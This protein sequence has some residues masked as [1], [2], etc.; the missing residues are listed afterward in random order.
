[1]TTF[2]QYAVFGLGASAIY[3]LLALGLIVI[4]SGSGV[5][6]FA[7]AAMATLGA[8]L[9]FEMRYIHGWGFWPAFLFGV[10]VITLIGVLIYHLVMRPLRDASALAK[11]IASLGILILIQGVIAL[12]WHENPRNVNAIFPTT[13]HQIGKVLIPGDRIYLVAIAV[14]ATAL[15]W[16]ASKY[17]PIGLAIRASAENQRAAAT[18]GWSPHV[19]ATIS[20]ALGAGLAGAAGILIAPVT[21]INPE[22]MPFFILPVLAAALVGGF[23]SFW[24]TLA[25][26]FAI[27]IT[28][29][30]FIAYVSDT[31]YTWGLK[32][33]LPFLIIIVLLVVRGE[34]LPVRGQV[35]E[36][37]SALGTGKVRWGWLAGVMAAFVAGQLLWFDISLQAALTV[38]FGWAIV[39]L[40]VV[41]LLGYTGQLSLA[42]FALAGIASLVAARLVGERGWP[43]EFAASLAV[44]VTIPVG[45]LF[46]IPALRTRGINLAVVTLG[47]AMGVNAMIF[48][49]TKWVGSSGFTAVPPQHLFGIDIDPITHI[50]TYGIVAFVALVLCS[51]SVASIRRGVVGRRLIAVRTNERAA[52]ALGISVFGV[53]LYAFAFGAAI[54]A[55]GGVIL[56]FR[57]TT[58]A[59]SD[60][61]PLASILAVAYTV[62]GGVGYVLGAPFGSQLVQGGFGTLAARLVPLVGRARPR[63]PVRVPRCAPRPRVR[64]G[65]E[66]PVPGATRCAPGSAR[67]CC[68]ASAAPGSCS[69]SRTARATAGGARC[70][71]TRIRAG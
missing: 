68:S 32:Q 60:Y 8:Y 1:M 15:L 29:S 11:T 18:L 36:K 28:Q 39:M 40:S 56:T 59:Y 64:G 47:L 38:S 49:N 31:G 19:L 3:T 58:V 13:I 20:W 67:C 27:G 43:V 61:T 57:T 45:L 42:Q 6:N 52:A 70:S 17:T 9:Y 53:K 41:V 7:Q 35:V 37:M 14:L 12:K 62:I 2:W 5:L 66:R 34:G 55:I 46:A 26:S 10:A 4:Y 51:L 63:R 25:A 30:E 44:A 48:T 16:A 21:G 54:A 50:A 33:T 65:V 69:R 23:T 24:I 71:R 22:E